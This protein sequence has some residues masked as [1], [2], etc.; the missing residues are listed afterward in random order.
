MSKRPVYFFCFMCFD[1]F[2]P[3]PTLFFASI[4]L[5]APA[6]PGNDSLLASSVFPLLCLAPDSAQQ[7]A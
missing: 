1:A 3:G 4:E 5:D 6:V 2:I 7:P